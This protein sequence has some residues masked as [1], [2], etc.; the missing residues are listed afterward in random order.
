MAQV[1]T[2]NVTSATPVWFE[3][4]LF[5]LKNET[6]NTANAIIGFT[7]SSYKA[8]IQAAND[9]QLTDLTNASNYILDTYVATKNNTTNSTIGQ[10]H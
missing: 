3:G 8:D 4:T 10:T 1:F 5:S 2:E 9:K 7:P 6:N